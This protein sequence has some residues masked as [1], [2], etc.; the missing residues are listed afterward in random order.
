MM[1]VVMQN[2]DQEDVEQGQVQ[3]VMHGKEME[4]NRYVQ[5]VACVCTRNVM[6]IVANCVLLHVVVLIYP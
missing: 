2:I 1:Q 3:Y 4:K 5:P 6:P